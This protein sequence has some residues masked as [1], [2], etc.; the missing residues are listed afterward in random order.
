MLR[1]QNKI[2]FFFRNFGDATRYYSH[3]LVRRFVDDDVL[4]LASGIAFN[5]LLC[6]IPLL[7]LLSSFLGSMLNSS[8][9]A[10]QNIYKFLSKALPNQSQ[11]I[12]IKNLTFRIINDM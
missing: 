8:D 2:K 10:T 9:I 1:K 6:V 12:G 11:A 7:L 4:F 3:G 5:V